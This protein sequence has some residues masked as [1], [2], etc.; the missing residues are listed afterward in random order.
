MTHGPQ[1]D[2]NK[3]LPDKSEG[4]K[5][6]AERNKDKADGKSSGEAH[7]DMQNHNKAIVDQVQEKRKT[8]R[9]GATSHGV[10]SADSLLWKE[11]QN[12]DKQQ[13]HPKAE[14]HQQAESRNHQKSEALAQGHKADAA[15]QNHHEINAQTRDVLIRLAGQTVIQEAQHKLGKVMDNANKLLTGIGKG[16]Q[17]AV[18][19][20]V[21]SIGVAGDYYGKALT[22]KTNFGAD[23]E[24]F[25]KALAD[26][27]GQAVDTAADYY[28]N[29]VPSG[30]NDLG[31]DIGQAG[32]AAAD[33]WNSMDWEQKGHFIGKDIV[34]LAAPGAVGMVAKDAEIANAVSKAG[35]AISSF[36]KADKM[37]AIEEKF[38]KIPG[39]LQKMQELSQPLKPAYATANDASHRP[40][41]PTE[42]PK[43]ADHYLAMKE[44]KELPHQGGENLPKRADAADKINEAAL[45]KDYPPKKLNQDE[46][47]MK[48][49]FE[50][51][52][53]FKSMKDGTLTA[54]VDL[55][56][57]P[58][59][60]AGQGSFT[61]LMATLK[62]QAGREGAKI[63]RVEGDFKNP[64]L[65]EIWSKRYRPERDGTKFKLEIKLKKE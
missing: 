38:S 26:G 56:F 64:D 61:E 65:D 54:K 62:R 8:R 42:T 28:L 5:D 51:F 2:H 17:E 59:N 58:R 18:S 49:R 9:S 24:Q 10:A 27:T 4:Q 1:Q 29:K 37:A 3:N 36:A 11:D 25:G 52:E 13:H 20:T 47:G 43:A 63:L 14:A 45:P 12:K 32:K 30:Q 33:K 48:S 6:R 40:H 22:G 53:V 34:P 57:N 15:G 50:V 21:N 55:V 7:Q 31:K 39:N 41:V 44:D 46:L 16:M 23:V 35:D 19:E 60:L